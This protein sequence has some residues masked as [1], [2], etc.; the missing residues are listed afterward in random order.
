MNS[1]SNQSSERD[2][3]NNSSPTDMNADSVSWPNS[4]ET[5]QFQRAATAI[6]NERPHTISAGKF[7]SIRFRT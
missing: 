2:K 1:S 7:D 3:S 4:Q 6:L 5:Q